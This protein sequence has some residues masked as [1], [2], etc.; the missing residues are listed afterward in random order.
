VSHFDCKKPRSTVNCQECVAMLEAMRPAPDRAAKVA[1]VVADTPENIMRVVNAWRR[2]P[3]G[4]GDAVNAAAVLRELRRAA[5]LC[6][7]GDDGPRCAQCDRRAIAALDG[8][9]K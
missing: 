4:Y 5:G 8:G 3:H 2:A 1:A 9:G 6:D 7:C